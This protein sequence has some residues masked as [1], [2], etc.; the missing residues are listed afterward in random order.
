MGGVFVTNT[1][2]SLPLGTHTGAGIST[3][4]FF[5]SVQNPNNPN[6]IK[7]GKFLVS[8][9]LSP[10]LTRTEAAVQKKPSADS[11]VGSRVAADP[12]MRVLDADNMIAAYLSVLFSY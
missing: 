12:K 6:I 4:L 5:D 3:D 1:E 11:P 2:I 10:V 7:L 8:K 9:C